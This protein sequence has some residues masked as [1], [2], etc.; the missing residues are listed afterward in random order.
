MSNENLIVDVLRK[1]DPILYQQVDGG[2][3]FL[4]AVRKRGAR[5]KLYRSYERGDH[6]ANLTKQQKYLLNISDDDAELNEA[7]SNYCGIVIDMM[8]GRISVSEITSR[9]EAQ[10]E[11]ITNTLERNAFQSKQNEWIRGAIRDSESYVIV[12]PQTALWISEPAYDGFS[13]MIAIYDPITQLPIWACKLYA[14]AETADISSDAEDL[15]DQRIINIVVYQ[16]GQISYWYGTDGGAEVSPRNII[17]DGSNYRLWELGVIP[18]VQLANK[19]DNYTPYGESEIRPVIPLQDIING[20]LY[21]MMMASKLSAFK[22]YWSKGIPLDNDGIVPGSILNIVPKD[23]GS[24]PI[25]SMDAET[26]AWW[27]SVEVGEFGGTD[28]SQYTNQLDKLEREISQVSS[29]PVYG[30]TAQGNLSGEALKQLES[31][32]IGKIYR[33]QN[34]NKGAIEKLLRLTAEVQR[35]FD[36]NRSFAGRLSDKVMSFLGLREPTDPPKKLDNISINWASP[37]I[38]NVADQMNALSQLR[39]DNPGL[40]PDEWYRERIGALLDM[41]SSQIK[42]EGE[43]AQTQSALALDELIGGGGEVPP[44]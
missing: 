24:N 37:E 38:I 17:D 8:A 41:S 4:S 42:A 25:T 22:L 30:I 29:T 6:R 35:S 11:W 10:N 13:G 2:S 3:G 34:E 16:P 5:V 23:A 32:L 40:W 21:D 39:R 44:V 19:R 20:T 7:A 43:K 9:D 36:V 33:F 1:T 12:D 26:A 31:G 14:T 27:E 15:G 18:A 28:M